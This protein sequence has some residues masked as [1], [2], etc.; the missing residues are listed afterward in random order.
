VRRCKKGMRN[1][2]YTCLCGR[3]IVFLEPLGHG[4]VGP[5]NCGDCGRG[6]VFTLRDDELYFQGPDYIMQEYEAIG[7]KKIQLEGAAGFWIKINEK[8]RRFTD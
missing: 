1:I 7:N 5:P 8:E 2:E 4:Y 3:K 6:G